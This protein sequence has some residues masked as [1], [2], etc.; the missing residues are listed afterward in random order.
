MSRSRIAAII[1][2]AGEGTRLNSARP[3]VLHEI[4]GR[5][6]IGHVLAALRPLEPAATV[7]VI[8][9]GT[10]EVARAV[11]PALTAIQS[12]PRGTA[13]AVRAARPALAA[14]LES[15]DIADVIVLYGDTPLLSTATIEALIEARRRAPAAAV[16]VAGFRPADPGPYGRLIL[17]SDGALARIVEA[18]DANAEERAI[19]LCNGGLMAIAAD[20]AFDLVD[21]IGNDNAK[22]EFYLTD[23]VA[24]A[25]ADGLSCRIAELP[26]EEV[27]G[28]NTRAEL[29]EA[30]ALMQQR[31]R[32]R[33]IAAGATLVAPETVFLSAD[34]QLGR[35][36]VI[37]PNVVF[38]PGVAVADNARI[39]AFSHLEGATVGEGAIVGPFA[40]L[41][42][43][44]VLERDVHVG[45]FV[46]VKAT[47]L[48]AGVKASHLTYLGDSDIGAGTNIGAGTITCNYDGFNKHRTTIGTGV[49]I[50]SNTALV[51]PVA[52]GD[53]AIVGAGS[54][55]TN[56]I[57]ADALTIARGR[58]ADK[59]GR[60][61]ELRARL[62][63]EKG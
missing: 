33:A 53:G 25:R 38:G 24:L 9:E 42:P 7:V 52:V 35:D 55:V 57:P 45:N 30:E 32:R 17:D 51:A 16:A 62:R 47:R 8:G 1:L 50:G 19:G 10:V 40:R 20:R 6:M 58:Q 21:R 49:F 41:R 44:A 2:A 61:A 36:V 46:E 12:P 34:T 3:K 59:P 5:P 27:V 37:E 11:A 22:R 43:G 60:A 4:A 48:G 29:A 15:G 28:V 13:D 18:K 23:I 56:D 31:L 14:A 54:V 26:A 63:K 39:R